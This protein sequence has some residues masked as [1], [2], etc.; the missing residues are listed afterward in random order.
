MTG[1]LESF[2][3]KTGALDRLAYLLRSASLGFVT[4]LSVM[5]LPALFPVFWILSAYPNFH[6]V[7]Q[8]LRSMG[9][10]TGAVRVIC[11]LIAL[12]IPIVGIIFALVLLFAAP[13]SSVKPKEDQP[14]T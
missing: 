10:K 14:V 7:Q 4:M 11:W 8:R 13:G 9:A 2:I 3:S 5:A 6:I 12:Q 1:F